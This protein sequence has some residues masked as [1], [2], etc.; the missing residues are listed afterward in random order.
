[1]RKRVQRPANP[2]IAMRL[3]VQQFQPFRHIRLPLP[4][5]PATTGIG[6]TPNAIGAFPRLTTLTADRVDYPD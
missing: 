5:L 6:N 3:D 1:M 2:H 4:S